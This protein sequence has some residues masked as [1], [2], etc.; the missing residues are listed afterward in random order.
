MTASAE[1]AVT[2]ADSWQGCG[3]GRLLLERLIEVARRNGVR[4]LT[5]DVLATNARMIRLAQRLG[6]RVVLAPRGGDAATLSKALDD[7]LQHSSARL[8]RRPRTPKPERRLELLLGQRHHARSALDDR[9]AQAPRCD[10]KWSA[11]NRA[12]RDLRLQKRSCRLRALASLRCA[13]SAARAICHPPQTIPINFEERHRTR[14][15]RL[16]VGA[17]GRN[18]PVHALPGRSRA[19]RKPQADRFER[20]A[21]SLREHRRRAR[22]SPSA[23][24]SRSRP[25]SR[26]ILRPIRSF[27]WMPVVPS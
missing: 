9:I 18:D 5:G 12:V 26:A 21:R 10:R 2:V 4:C 20:L 15:H 24:P 8:Q 16:D 11:K 3:L 27:A 13:A 17:V 25:P 1:I 7:E 23:P 19:R 14:V 22:R 6:F